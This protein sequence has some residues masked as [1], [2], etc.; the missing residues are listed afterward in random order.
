MGCFNEIDAI[1]RLA[2]LSSDKVVC[3]LPIRLIHKASRKAKLPRTVT[4]PLDMRNSMLPSAGYDRIKVFHGTYDDYGGLN[5]VDTK[6]FR[7]MQDHAATIML[8]ESTMEFVWNEYKARAKHDADSR[9][10]TLDYAR[11]FAMCNKRLGELVRKKGKYAVEWGIG[12]LSCDRFKLD[13]DFDTLMKAHI[14]FEHSLM[15]P[16]PGKER[17]LTDEEFA[18]V[19]KYADEWNRV[20]FPLFWYCC[21]CHINP[22]GSVEMGTQA[23]FFGMSRNLAEFTA[24]E[25][26]RILGSDRSMKHY[27]EL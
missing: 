1:T 27:D 24:K 16:L 9:K 22:I 26:T 10:R 23:R 6:E 12:M 14:E 13:A 11:T 3:L 8:R 7:D 19:D 5:E 18:I 25:A 4:T 15:L 2:I 17:E 20:I 21:R